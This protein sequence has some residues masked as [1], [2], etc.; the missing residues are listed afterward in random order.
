MPQA[1]AIPVYSVRN[2]LGHEISV[3]ATLGSF[4]HPERGGAE[5]TLPCVIDALNR[6]QHVTGEECLYAFY[7]K[8][9]PAARTVQQVRH[10]AGRTFAASRG[11]LW[12]RA[13]TDHELQAALAILR[14]DYD[15][16][17]VDPASN[18][19]TS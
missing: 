8:P 1:A 11:V 19:E 3:V 13:D 5:T 10:A 15:V 6:A 17:A 16:K 4:N 7:L 12:L 18:K 2:P 14:A 9:G